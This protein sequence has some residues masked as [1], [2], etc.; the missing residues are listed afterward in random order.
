ML[1]LSGPM[2][3]NTKLGE[4]STI[5]AFATGIGISCHIY[6]ASKIQLVDITSSSISPNTNYSPRVFL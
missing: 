2:E 5:I 4:Y 6:P 1:Y 3:Y